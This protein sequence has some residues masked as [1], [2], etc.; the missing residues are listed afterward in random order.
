MTKPQ[1]VVV[2]LAW[3]AIDPIAWDT[4]TIAAGA[5]YQVAH[6]QLAVWRRLQRLTGTRLHF[7]QLRFGDAVIG[8]C[9][10]KHR[11][12]VFA[13]RERLMLLP[14]HDDLWTDA[15]ASVLEHLGTGRYRY[16]NSKSISS[17]R[18]AQFAGMRG[19]TISRTVPYVVQA[20]DFSAHDDWESYWAMLKGNVR[21]N[22][23]RAA[24]EHDLWLAT[25]H[26]KS[27]LAH[28]PGFARALA[29]Q[30]HRKGARM[31]MLIDIRAM[32]MT[33][34]GLANAA[35]LLR[36]RSGRRTLAWQFHVAFGRDVYYVAGASER[37]QPSPA[38]WLTIKALH[39]AWTSNP[40]GKVV[41]G[42]FYP[43]I[44]DEANGGGILQWRR[45]CRA[46]DF[47]G[48]VVHFDYTARPDAR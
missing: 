45:H 32:V 22:F 2:P 27:I 31:Q 12:G 38:W 1:I 5:S 44:H 28:V 24:D 11:R 9:V 46:R 41:L 15:M 42:P 48:C 43:E 10:V 33:M 8:Q 16:G 13:I 7:L 6:A 19:V 20:V 3:S 26:G 21:R 37:M 36:A 14:Q 34:A 30:V 35:K 23:R 25:D 29:R 18:D 17:A 40:G 47:P 39:E 4:T